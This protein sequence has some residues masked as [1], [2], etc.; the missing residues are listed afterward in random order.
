MGLV[1]MAAGAPMTEIASRARQGLI[2]PG[3]TAG[4]DDLVEVAGPFTDSGAIKS[5]QATTLV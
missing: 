2:P 5:N 4:H 3:A 1:L